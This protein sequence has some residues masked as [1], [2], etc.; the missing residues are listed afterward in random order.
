MR[1]R[2]RGNRTGQIRAR[3][4]RRQNITVTQHFAAS[5]DGTSIPYF[6]VRPRGRP[7]PDFALRLRRVSASCTPGYSGVLGRL[8]LAR[9]GTYVL[10]NIRGGGEY[11]PGWHTQTMRAAV[12]RWRRTSL[13]WRPIWSTVASPPCSNSAPRRRNGG[14]LMGIMLTKYPENLAALVSDCL[15]SDMKPL[16]P[17]FA[18]RSSGTNP[19]NQ[20]KCNKVKIHQINTLPYPNFQPSDQAVAPAHLDPCAPATTRCPVR[21]TA[22]RSEQPPSKPAGY[23]VL[24]AAKKNM[25]GGHAAIGGGQRDSSSSRR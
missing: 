4:L 13:P 19:G 24:T 21:A 16:S 7:R 17:S 12:T 11:G 5:K 9:G 2:S 10:A 25:D 14:L 23:R 15:C 3:F 18:A 6:V 1:G 22:G 20:T 8:W